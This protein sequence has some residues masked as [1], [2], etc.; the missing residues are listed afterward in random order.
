MCVIVNNVIVKFVEDDIVLSFNMKSAE[1]YSVN[2]QWE[3]SFVDISTDLHLR[4]ILQLNDVSN[5]N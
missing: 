5:N 2:D 4:K 3:K 1:F